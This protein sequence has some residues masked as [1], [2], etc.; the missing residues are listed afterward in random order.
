MIVK[1]DL[2]L[3]CKNKERRAQKELYEILVPYLA[4]V[5]RR[6][7]RNPSDTGDTLQETFISLFKGIE[8]Y[9]ENKA[10]F[11]TWAVRI[12]INCSLKMNEKMYKVETLDLHPDQ[13]KE[14]TRPSILE[15]LDNEELLARLKRMPKDYFEVFNLIVV[16]GYSH[17]EVAETLQVSESLSRQRLTRARKWIHDRFEQEED[18]G[19]RMSSI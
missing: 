12:A 8:S 15:K 9:D 16:D 4:T 18:E 7:L 10:E 2:V 11:R 3:R 13:N 19:L 1:K 5:C 17:R 6:Y 14:W